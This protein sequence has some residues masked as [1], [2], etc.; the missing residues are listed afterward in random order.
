MDKEIKI[1]EILVI[2]ILKLS[3]KIDQNKESHRKDA[4]TKNSS[5]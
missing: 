5:K 4:R 2:K 1:S 3:N